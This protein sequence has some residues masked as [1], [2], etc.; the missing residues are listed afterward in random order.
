MLLALL[1]MLLGGS[2][3]ARARTAAALPGA[4]QAASPLLAQLA[5]QTDDDHLRIAYHAETG[6]VRF[7][8]AD[9]QRPFRRPALLAASAGPEPAARAFLGSYGALFGVDEQARD[10]SVMRAPAAGS[11]TFV[12]FQQH[13][14][15][16]PVLAGEIVVQVDSQRDV[17]SANGEI[18]PDIG[19][20]ITPSI[21]KDAARQRA[22]ALVAQTYDT[23]PATLTVSEPALWVFNPALLGGPGQRRTQL[24]WR[25]EVRG[26]AH[27]VAIRELVL[28]DAHVGTTALHFNQIAGARERHVCN[29][30]NIPDLDGDERNNCTPAKYVRSE[31]Q[32]ATG[33]ADVD[34]AYDYSGATYDFYKSNFNRD[35]LDDNGL[36]LISLVKYCPSSAECPYANAGW[37]GQQM[38][39]GNG[40]ASADDVVGHELT[41][42][43]TEFSSG[44]FYYYQ[45]GAINESMSDV[46]GELIDLT[47]GRGTD[48]FATRWQIGEDLPAAFGVLRD[49]QDPT[50]YGD[51]DRMNSPFYIT[52]ANLSDL[53]G[54]HHNSGVNNKALYLMVD[55]AT[56]NGYTIRGLG[57]PK[58]AQ[59]YY[60]V[61]NSLLTSGS[62]YQDLGDALQ[63]ACAALMGQFGITADDC[64]QVAKVVKATEMDT[65]P[66]AAP[67]IDAPVCEAGRSAG[68]VFFDNLEDPGN[69]KWASAPVVGTLN[70]WSYPQSLATNP[71]GAPYATSGVNNF[72]GD[73]RAGRP[74]SYA[75]AMKQG[76]AIPANAFLHFNH[77]YDFGRAGSFRLTGGVV[78]YSTNN[79]ASWVDAAPLFTFNGYNST[80]YA[81]N[82]NP[83]ASRQAF[84]GTSYGYLSSRLDL[85]SLA[86]QSARFRFRIGTDASPGNLG[87]FVDDVR[88]FTCG[89]PPTNSAPLLT[90]SNDITVTR[91]GDAA[92]A[93]VATASDVQDR[94]GTL[95]IAISGLPSGMMATASNSNG[96]ISLTVSGG[97]T[98][99]E[100]TYQITLQARD[101]G[102][103]VATAKVKVIVEQA[104]QL[105]KD[106]SFELG[107][108]N[109]Y[110]DATAFGSG[111][112]LCDTVS[113]FV[114][115]TAG[116][117]SGEWW[118]RFGSPIGTSGNGF[119]EQTVAIPPGDARLEFYLRISDHS[120]SG[121]AD[122]VRLLVDGN[123]VFEVTDA[124]TAYDNVYRKVSIDL[125]Q[126]SG[127]SRL[128]RFQE[129]NVAGSAP[130]RV[131]VDDVT[132][133]VTPNACGAGERVFLPV[134]IG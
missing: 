121:T 124:T 81:N 108:P 101:S 92:K 58:A 74:A 88:I 73:D 65:A 99:A 55:G 104:G 1:F 71:I 126:F 106:R 89:G 33:V 68:N 48:T 63:A 70:L 53:G 6:K 134:V 45:A 97:C 24:V 17:V 83:L 112:L 87:W 14:Q 113:C 115:A 122:Y 79:G 7:V 57:I 32:A 129:R 59:I 38:T 10:L 117:R 103:L 42:G 35:S 23:R 110:W 54:V 46:F 86:G 31:G 36:P 3:M 50:L 96:I 9:P 12:R 47:D 95:D 93:E 84:T 98:T 125:A 105:I 118:A 128:I 37:D 82:G 19:L 102:N 29:D 34:L 119:V 100:G 77:A 52:D 11:H 30:K 111:A 133:V 91:G 78:E 66:K 25:V 44:L 62:D 26:D 43:F 4:R 116:P 13:Y 39:Y 27:G 114:S 8:G 67:A 72:W 120:G 69:P 80:I 127:S 28:V 56:F 18:L 75:M 15:G 130:F 90:V 20:N 49:M 2:G 41:H 131:H 123:Q 16:I 94:A 5:G 85:S 21:A 40:F 61:N 109:P 51:A 76:V 107:D 22:L 60:L 132:L 64:A